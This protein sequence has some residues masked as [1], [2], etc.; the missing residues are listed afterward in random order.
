MQFN[1]ETLREARQTWRTLSNAGVTAEPPR[2]GPQR[3]A[4]TYWWVVDT[5]ETNED[6]WLLARHLVSMTNH[7][8]AVQKELA[9]C[10]QEQDHWRTAVEQMLSRTGSSS[11]PLPRD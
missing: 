2:R 10:R 1:H 7:L 5:S 9:L 11:A 3:K 4:K 6:F 8:A